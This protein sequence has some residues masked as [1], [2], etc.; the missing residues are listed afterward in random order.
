MDGINYHPN[1]KS[2]NWHNKKREE[3]K[4]EAP[5]ASTSNPQ[6]SQPPKEGNNNKKKHLKRPYSPSY[7]LP[8]I[9]NDAMDNV[10]NISRTLITFKD[11]EEKRMRK[12]H[13]PKK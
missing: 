5:V 6:A 3:I 1:L 4:E 13:F 11:K 8:R 7:R 9:Q 2:K 10:F 12:P